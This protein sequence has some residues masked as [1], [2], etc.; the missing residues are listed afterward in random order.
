MYSAIFKNMNAAYFNL[1]VNHLPIILPVAGTMVMIIDFLFKPDAVFIS[2][3]M[4]QK[5]LIKLYE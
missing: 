1:V 2:I 5:L 4:R 3:K